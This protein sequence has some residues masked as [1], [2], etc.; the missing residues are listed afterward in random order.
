MSMRYFVFKDDESFGPMELEELRRFVDGGTFTD[1][2]PVCLENSEEWST[3]GS[4]LGHELQYYVYTDEYYGPLDLDA[5][6]HYLTTGVFAGE[7]AACIVGS[8]QWLSISDL[9]LSEEATAEESLAQ[10]LSRPRDRAREVKAIEIPSVWDEDAQEGRVPVW[11]PLLY[12]LLT[13]TLCF[14]SAGV[15]WF[16]MR[17]DTAY[18][19]MQPLGELID[20]IN[21][22][23]RALHLLGHTIR[24]SGEYQYAFEEGIVDIDTDVRL[25]GSHSSG[26]LFVK[27]ER[28]DGLW[29]YDNI[30][31]N[32]DSDTSGM[33][34]KINLL[35][36]SADE[37]ETLVGSTLLSF[38]KALMSKDFS[39]FHAALH[40][41][42][43]EQNTPQELLD[44]FKPFVSFPFE[45][46]N[47]LIPIFTAIELDD[48]ENR[49]LLVGYYQL[50]DKR[51]HFQTTFQDF[52]KR[53]LLGF[54]F[55][56]IPL[57]K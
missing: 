27:A 2:M 53:K 45:E 56:V 54:N 28:T 5:I 17:A 19:T 43:Q 15:V 42:F 8:E 22:D 20:F 7:H 39:D 10:P 1:T 14:I 38:S 46:L 4:L 41:Q 47:G 48:V 57:S 13:L 35:I 26:H 12:V 37:R 30:L 18:K 21:T 33:G 51:L 11:K 16:S 50:P 6:K 34:F 31:L 9:L 44:I 3:V 40:P 49:I 29:N 32:K 25:L 36:P 23:A 24:P 52:P 55:E